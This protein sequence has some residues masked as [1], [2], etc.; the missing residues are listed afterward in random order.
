MSAKRV[1]AWV[2]DLFRFGEAAQLLAVA[3]ELVQAG[4]D[5]QLVSGHRRGRETAEAAAARL[6]VPVH[7]CG[8][9]GNQRVA[10]RELAALTRSLRPGIVHNWCGPA[11]VDWV[12]MSHRCRRVLTL[13]DLL[14]VKQR[15]AGFPFFPAGVLLAKGGPGIKGNDLIQRGKKIP[16]GYFLE[17]QLEPVGQ[18]AIARKNV[19][20]RL[21]LNGDAKLALAIAPLDPRSRLKD[22]IWATDL[23]YCIRDDVHLLIV[24]QGRQRRSLERWTRLMEAASNVHILDEVDDPAGL[25]QAVDFF[26][27]AADGPLARAAVLAAMKGKTPV[28]TVMGQHLPDLVRH[29]QTALQVNPGSR[30]AFA[31]WTK[32]LLEQTPCR[33]QLVE[34]ARQQAESISGNGTLAESLTRVYFD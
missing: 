18:P 28:I 3:K 14:D 23:L 25:I 22:L 4:V 5:L 24:G 30:E 7:F 21:F 13:H 11:W 27:Q 2:P 33:E 8:R 17:Q 19:E 26:W 31:R 29:Q 15:L 6:G 20:T 32:Y 34:Q 12:W 10:W 1:L 16:V 9:S